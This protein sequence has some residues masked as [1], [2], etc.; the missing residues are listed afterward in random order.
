[1]GRRF[2]RVLFLSFAVVAAAL[3]A[4]GVYSVLAFSIARRTRE[5]GIRVA[6]GANRRDIISLVLKEGLLL[7]VIGI[8]VGLGAA[9]FLATPLARFLYGV[10]SR[11]PLTF[12]AAPGL[13]LVI[14]VL[15]CLIPARKATRVQPTT[16]LRM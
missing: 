2:T 15:A 3:A 4:I 11:D 16:A 10:A 8:V 1:V 12:A 13:L 9:M 14:A 7:A 5:L 6:L